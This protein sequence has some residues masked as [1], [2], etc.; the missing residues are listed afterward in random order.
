MGSQ[1]LGLICDNR[2]IVAPDSASLK[3]AMQATGLRQ[4]MLAWR[5]TKASARCGLSKWPLAVEQ[6]ALG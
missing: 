6:V 4:V 3:G 1:Q 5:R 2:S